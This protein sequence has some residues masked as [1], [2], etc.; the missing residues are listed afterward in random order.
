MSEEDAQRIKEIKSLPNKFAV[1]AIDWWNH[2]ADEVLK[3]VIIVMAYFEYLT[4]S[5]EFAD[6][7]L[8]EWS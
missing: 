7:A 1:E 8:E 5:S 6:K 3:R 4:Q 2:H